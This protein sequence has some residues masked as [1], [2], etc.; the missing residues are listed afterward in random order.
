[1]FYTY[2]KVYRSITYFVSQIIPSGVQVVD[3]ESYGIRLDDPVGKSPSIAVTIEQ[4]QDVAIELGS[5][6]IQFNTTL[7]INAVSRLQRDAL[8]SIVH[9]GLVNN[10]IPVYDSFVDFVPNGVIE[11]YLC[12]GDYFSIKDMLNFTTNREKF[13]WVSVVFVDLELLGI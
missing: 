12:V 5:P 8:K 13:F 7:T 2:D 1:M 3:G 11:R 6:S 10:Q 4:S 9:S